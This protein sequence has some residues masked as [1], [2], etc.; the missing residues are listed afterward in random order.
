[1]ITT[2][3][4]T[5]M[6]T[7]THIYDHCDYCN[8][9]NHCDYYNTADHCDYCV[10]LLYYTVGMKSFAVAGRSILIWDQMLP[11]CLISLNSTLCLK[12][13]TH[14]L[15]STW[16]NSHDIQT[17]NIRHAIVLKLIF[18]PSAV[19]YFVLCLYSSHELEWQLYSWEWHSLILSHNHLQ[20]LPLSN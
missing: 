6:I 7:A 4:L 13:L 15:N 16:Y 9:Y 14:Q 8:T 12:I 2:M 5:T 20:T 17:E 10:M 11:L 1:M 3:H 19:W 18:A